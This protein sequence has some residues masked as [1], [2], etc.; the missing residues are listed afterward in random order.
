MLE[1]DLVRHAQE[2]AGSDAVEEILRRLEEDFVQGWK[3]TAPTDQDHREHCFRMVLAIRA[4]RTEIKTLAL[5][6]RVKAWNRRSL[7]ADTTLR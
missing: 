5:S 6:D 7:A 3:N 2:L 1:H 4:L